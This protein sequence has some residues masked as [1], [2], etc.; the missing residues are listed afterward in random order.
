M[1]K[2]D[3]PLLAPAELGLICVTS[4]FVRILLDWLDHEGLAAGDLR[5]DIA[6]LD[7]DALVPIPRWHELLQRAI[8]LRPGVSPAETG[9]AIGACVKPAH[10][11]LLGYLALASSTLEEALGSY[12]RFE[13]L[14]YGA[15]MAECS[16]TPQTVEIRWHKQFP[17][18]SQ[19]FD[20]VAISTLVSFMRRLWPEPPPLQHVSFVSPA[21]ADIAPYERFFGCPV[22]FGDSHVRVAF[23]AAYKA[24]PLPQADPALRALLDRQAEALAA[25]LPK[26]D[27]FLLE[28]QRAL[29]K[30]LPEGQS[31]L[32]ATARELLTSVRTLQRRLAERETSFQR[33]LDD[34][35]EQ[36]ARRY[37][38]D[39]SL[40]V[41]DVS[42]LLGYSGQGVFTRAFKE[43]TGDTPAAF[44]RRVGG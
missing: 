16:I 15:N 3:D 27:A 11:G 19:L 31:T 32:D 26:A 38:A 37:L 2:Q 30:L 42:L 5:A 36:L 33:V 1:H 34:T 23:S 12:L 17:R 39:P 28:L 14:F 7:S 8:A 44:R 21:P 35:R 41:M 4:A 24:L 29:L 25:A 13:K 9:L 10:V 22:R 40:S 20:D 18:P 6:A 43:W